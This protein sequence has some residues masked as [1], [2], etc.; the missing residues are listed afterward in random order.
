MISLHQLYEAQHTVETRKTAGIRKN[1]VIARNKAC[2]RE[3]GGDEAITEETR[4][5]CFAALPRTTVTCDS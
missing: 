5:D 3:G 1:T 2:P 4:K